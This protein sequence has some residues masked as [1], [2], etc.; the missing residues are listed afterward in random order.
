MSGRVLFLITTL[1]TAAA[2]H[3][4]VLLN[5][6]TFVMDRAIDLLK[7]EDNAFNQWLPS[8]PITPEN[9]PVVRASPDLAYTVCL[10]DLSSGPV[11]VTAATWPGY[12]SLSIFDHDT[13]NVHASSLRGDGSLSGVI[14]ATQDQQ[15][16][17]NTDLPVVRLSDETG[18]AL[19]RRLAPDADSRAQSDALN[20][21]GGCSP[22]T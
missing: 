2:V 6:P 21:L 12:G 9:Q 5:I 11:K 7:G 17:P 22:L 4:F 1:V 10:L 18:I 20:P 16:P 13:R 3:L 15:T 14:V 19:I 8:A